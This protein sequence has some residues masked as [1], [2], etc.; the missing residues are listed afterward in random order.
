MIRAYDHGRRCSVFSALDHHSIHCD[1]DV[2]LRIVPM[3]IPDWW[4]K[5]RNK[6]ILMCSFASGS[7]RRFAVQSEPPLALAPRLFFVPDFAGARC[8]SISGGTM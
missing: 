3:V 8:S 5:N 6:T 4:D 2:H 1:V 7:R